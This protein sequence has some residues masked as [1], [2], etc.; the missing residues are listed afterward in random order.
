MLWTTLLLGDPQLRR[1]ELVDAHVGLVRHEQVDVGHRHAGLG[2]HR[3]GDLRHLLGR[4]AEH[5]LA[6]HRG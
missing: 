3:V 1:D 6:V 5:L 2:E 4:P